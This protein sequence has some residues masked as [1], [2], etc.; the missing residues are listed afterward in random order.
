MYGNSVN[1]LSDLCIKKGVANATSNDKGR[2]AI[3]DGET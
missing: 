1:M 3:N 2:V